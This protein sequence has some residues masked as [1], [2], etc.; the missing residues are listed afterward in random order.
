MEYIFFEKDYPGEVAVFGVPLCC[1]AF[2]HALLRY[3]LPSINGEP[4]VTRLVNVTKGTGTAEGVNKQCM[5]AGTLALMRALARLCVC[6]NV[7]V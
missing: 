3:T 2:G 5:R 4:P 1:F 7:C 6:A